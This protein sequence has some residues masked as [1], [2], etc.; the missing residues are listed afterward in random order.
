MKYL[1]LF[2]R[3]QKNRGVVSPGASSGKGLAKQENYTLPAF[4]SFFSR[5][6]SFNDLEAGFL[7]SLFSLSFDFPMA[8]NFTGYFKKQ[9]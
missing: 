6:F 2:N 3:T 7:T 8:Y 1:Y 4:F 9:I 5:R